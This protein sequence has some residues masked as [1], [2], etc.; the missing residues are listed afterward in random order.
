MIL[1]VGFWMSDFELENTLL[2]LAV[3][4][5]PKVVASQIEVVLVGAWYFA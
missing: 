1:W 5:L 4:F 3:N 2:N